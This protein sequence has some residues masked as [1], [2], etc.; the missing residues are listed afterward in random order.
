[1]P[2]VLDVAT[3]VREPIQ[4]YSEN[5]FD[6]DADL[7]D[8]GLYWCPELGTPRRINIHLMFNFFLDQNDFF[9]LGFSFQ[10]FELGL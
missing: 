1:V 7:S 4:N 3:P 6:Q 5:S 9:I 8:F 10:L 2:N